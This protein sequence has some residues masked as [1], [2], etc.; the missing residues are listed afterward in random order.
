M[1]RD[2]ARQ[3]SQQSQS[4]PMWWFKKPDPTLV[5]ADVMAHLAA[6]IRLLERLGAGERDL[7]RERLSLLVSRLRIEGRGGFEPNGLERLLIAALALIPVLRLGVDWLKPL[8][9]VL[10]YPGPFSVPINYEPNE[11]GIVAV[12]RETRHGEAWLNGPVVLA[13][14]EVE[15][16]LVD[17]LAHGSVVIHEI[18]HVIDASNG[19]T[20]GMPE[21]P[22][23]ID[24]QLWTARFSHAYADH[25]QRVDRDWPLF[26]DPYAAEAPEEF[27]A[28]ATEA[29]FCAPD[30]LRAGYPE[31]HALLSAFYDGRAA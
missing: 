16:D 9:L 22:A 21:L 6:R 10:V 17:G 1:D 14:S 15:Q 18:A 25:C 19:S 23:H 13:W 11:H 29:Y 26:L 2:G 31:V 27:F 5:P 8:R 7:F 4:L 24:R 12:G 30:S 3:V 28:V 20:N